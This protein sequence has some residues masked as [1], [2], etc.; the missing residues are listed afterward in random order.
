M[1]LQFLIHF[2]AQSRHA[3]A[4]IGDFYRSAEHGNLHVYNG[5]TLTR[6]EFE[7][8]QAKLFGS[9]HLPLRPLVKIIETDEP[10]VAS[11]PEGVTDQDIKDM[12]AEID[13]LRGEVSRLTAENAVLVAEKAAIPEIVEAPTEEKPEEKPETGAKPAKPKKVK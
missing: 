8:V 5:R 1:A 13:R 4:R 11:L 6:E 9:D 2:P 12:L 3:N 10:A 7:K